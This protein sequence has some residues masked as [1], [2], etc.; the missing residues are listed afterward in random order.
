MGWETGLHL[1]LTLVAVIASIYAAACARRALLRQRLLHQRGAVAAAAARR[2]VRGEMRRILW[3]VAQTH[4]SLELLAKMV[5]RL[6]PHDDEDPPRS[7]PRRSM[8]GDGS[9]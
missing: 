9:S 3:S 6:M 5:L 7:G 2:D 1:G 8:P 4:Q